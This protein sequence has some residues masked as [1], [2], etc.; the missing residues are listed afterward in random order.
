[1]FYLEELNK[2]LN[3]YLNNGNFNRKFNI[4]HGLKY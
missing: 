4:Y 2:K 1:M 3:K